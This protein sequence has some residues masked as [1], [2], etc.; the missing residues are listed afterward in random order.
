MY[1]ICKNAM[2]DG[3]KNDV[4]WRRYVSGRKAAIARGLC[5]PIGMKIKTKLYHTQ[6]EK[7]LI[8]N[9]V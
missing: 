7:M 4:F 3:E 8:L 1:H 5:V 6:A 2:P 9:G